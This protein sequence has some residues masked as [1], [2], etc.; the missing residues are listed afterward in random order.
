MRAKEKAFAKGLLMMEFSAPSGE[1]EDGRQ[2]EE[3]LFVPW[4][5]FCLLLAARP[6]VAQAREV[7]RAMGQEKGGLIWPRQPMGTRAWRAGVVWV[8][9]RAAGGKGL[10]GQEKA[11]KRMMTIARMDQHT[12]VGRSASIAEVERRK[13]RRKGRMERSEAKCRQ[14]MR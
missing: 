3:A 2:V 6:E 10:V 9:A 4:H 1:D 12:R 7:R 11:M 13:S 8:R 5:R 14:K